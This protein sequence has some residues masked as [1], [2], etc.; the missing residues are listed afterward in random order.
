MPAFSRVF[1]VR[2]TLIGGKKGPENGM[3]PSTAPLT[4]KHRDPVMSKNDDAA[5]DSQAI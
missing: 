3:H 2:V 4:P 1:G 5:E